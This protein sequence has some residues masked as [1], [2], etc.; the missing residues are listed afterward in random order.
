MGPTVMVVDDEPDLHELVQVILKREG[1]EVIPVES[2][3]RA[4]EMLE[5]EKPDLILL[6]IRMPGLDGWETLD[7]MARRGII[8]EVPVAMFTVEKLTFVRMLRKDIENLVGYIEKPFTRSELLETVKRTIDRTKKT[9]QLKKKIA[10]SPS[11]DEDLA[12][13]FLAWNRTQMIHE[14]L[15]EKLEHLKEESIDKQKLARVE[16]LMKGEERTIE[17]AERKKREILRLAGLEGLTLE[18]RDLPA[19]GKIKK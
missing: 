16:N 9:Y 7:E 18:D 3:E 2:G 19:G 12:K 11:G 15:R 4:L 14:R 1:Y 8:E 6:D 17:E 5:K 13:A 10:E